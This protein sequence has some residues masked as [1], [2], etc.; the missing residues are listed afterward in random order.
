[1]ALCLN[2]RG[3]NEG[4]KLKL[5]APPMD[6]NEL[7]DKL[8]FDVNKYYKRWGKTSDSALSASANKYPLWRERERERV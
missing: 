8:H 4:I 3:T 6:Q 1:M 7:I 2:K 5:A